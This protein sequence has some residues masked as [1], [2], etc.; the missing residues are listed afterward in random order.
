MP[1]GDDLGELLTRLANDAR[2]VAR[3]EIDVYRQ[4]VIA[5]AQ[6]AIWPAGMI[7]AALLLVFG[8]VSALLVGLAMWLA[9]W[10][11]ALGGGLA[12]AAIGLAI[13]GLLGWLA[14]ARFRRIFTDPREDGR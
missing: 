12:A 3:A 4:I 10:I 8:A 13:A 6:A 7:V 2:E 5:R 9:Q 14:A 1:E 11:G